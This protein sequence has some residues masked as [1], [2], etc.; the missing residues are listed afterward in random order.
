MG[1]SGSI[2]KSTIK[3]IEKHPKQF[4]LVGAS[5]HTNV[6]YLTKL[7][8]L[9]KLKELAL[10]GK[11]D[12]NKIK[13]SG[14][15]AI[16]ELINNTT[17]DIVVNGI[18]GSAG[19]IPSI[20]IIKKGLDLALAN[21]ETIVMAGELVKK[22]AKEN[23]VKILP[24]D[25]EHAALAELLHGKKRDEIE[26]L[27][28]TASGGPFLNRELSTFKYITIEQALAHPTWKMGKK[29]SIDSATM[30]NKGLELIEA[31][32]L[33][34]MDVSKIKIVIH[35]GSKVHSLIKTVEG[36]FFAQ[37]S[38]PDMS[39][40]ILNALSWPKK[41]KS[42]IGKLDIYNLNL[43]FSKPDFKRYPILKLAYETAEKKGAA[44]IIFNASNEAAVD[45]FLGGKIS[46]NQIPTVIENGLR[47]NPKI[48]LFNLEDILKLN[49][50]YYNKANRFC[51]AINNL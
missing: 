5:A 37:I 36:S 33:F 7:E 26:S 48:D 6:K 3:I 8:K 45:A 40:P 31:V 47:D 32:K 13:Y 9:F 20:T 35:P 11:T 43:S 44:P 12:T 1:A 38:D 4:T 27:W 25:S 15:N 18:A 10:S 23:D 39:L 34:D 46:Y 28:L 19:L 17:A 42:D 14:K 22:L 51:D 29:I 21:K 50:T 16:E 24:V 30:A 49:Q 41:I 2:G